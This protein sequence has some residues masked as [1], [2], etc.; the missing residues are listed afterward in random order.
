MLVRELLSILEDADPDAE[1]FVMMQKTWPF[2]CAVA[3]VALREEFEDVEDG[4]APT[5]SDGPPRRANDVFLV[6]G[7]QL[8]YGSKEAWNVA[9]RE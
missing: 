6:E 9:R 7:A 2:E 3:G 4:E 5:L 1:V 8:R